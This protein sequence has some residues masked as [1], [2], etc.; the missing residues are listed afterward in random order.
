MRV[1]P[2]AAETT[3]FRDRVSYD[4]MTGKA[5][6]ATIGF[7]D[8]DDVFHSRSTAVR[9]KNTFCNYLFVGILLYF[10][11]HSS[12]IKYLIRII[13]IYFTLS[14]ILEKTSSKALAVVSYIKFVTF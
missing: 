2:A 4:T 1:A 9:M 8:D 7:H 12:N 13:I 11:Q 10:I 14:T 3:T 5:V 6:V